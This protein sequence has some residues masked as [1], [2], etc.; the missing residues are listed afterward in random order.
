MDFLASANTDI[1]LTK[2]TNQDSLS[3]KV[4]NTGTGRMA[5]AILCDG[6]GGLAKGEAASASVIQAFDKWFFDELPKL[7]ND[8]MGNFNLFEQWNNII[9]KQNIA[10]RHYGER[11]GI[12]MGTTVVAIL[13]TQDKY[14]LMNIGDSR[15]YE[16]KDSLCQLTK[17]QTFIAREVERGK[18]TPKQAETDPRRSVLLQCVGASEIVRPDFFVGDSKI[19]TTYMLCSDGFRHE[20][21]P[22]EIYDR[23]R[24]ELLHNK[25][26][27]NQNTIE[28][29]ELN[30]QRKEQDNIS[31]VVIRT[32]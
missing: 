31:V 12:R 21:T 26:V 30:K 25:E 5:F 10:I 15:A 4:V 32:V 24:P 28:L 23:M 13:I 17:D 11:M 8:P 6:M 14:Y 1:G 27:I 3:L 20:I 2:K 29:I 16:I 7:V 18:L 19:N 22:R 9:Q